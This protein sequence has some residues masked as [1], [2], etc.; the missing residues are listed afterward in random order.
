MPPPTNNQAPTTDLTTAYNELGNVYDPQ[1]SQVNTALAAIPGQ[2]QAAMSSLDQAKANAF[3]DIG[4]TANNRGLLYS[5]Y[6]PYEQNDYT[7]NKYN[8]AVTDLNN[9]VADQTKTLQQKLTDINQSR[10]NAAQSLV[11]QTQDAQA[12]IDAQNA[13]LSTGSTASSKSLSQKD[14]TSALRQGLESVKGADG[15]VSPGNLAKAY[16]I[17][18]SQGLNP[19][20][21]WTNFQGYWN[22]NEGDYKQLFN[23]AK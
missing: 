3:R 12:K 7:T 11:S 6:S 14:T 13:K 10:S 1:T 15:H 20:S 23:A 4:T 9:K 19:N 22:P 21:F 2:Q 5:G 8:P 18:T 16:Q 17:W